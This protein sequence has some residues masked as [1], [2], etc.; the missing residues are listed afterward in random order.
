MSRNVERRPAGHSGAPSTT[1]HDIAVPVTSAS[2]ASHAQG[3]GS[4]VVADL[5]AARRARA[6]RDALDWLDHHGLCACWTAP[7]PCPYRRRWIS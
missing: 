3:S 2:D 5:S 1:R 4:G 6:L 7:R